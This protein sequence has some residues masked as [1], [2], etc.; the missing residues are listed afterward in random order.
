MKSLHLF[1]KFACLDLCQHQA[2]QLQRLPLA[3]AR[4]RAGALEWLNC[5]NYRY[6]SITPAYWPLVP[7]NL[8]AR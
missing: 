1:D 4:F 3:V 2:G 6:R 5:T 7:T 8:I